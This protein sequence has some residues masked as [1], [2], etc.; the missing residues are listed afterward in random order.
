MEVQAKDE[1]RINEIGT[2]AHQTVLRTDRGQSAE[3]GGPENEMD[4]DE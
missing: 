2:E 4:D 1:S 3:V